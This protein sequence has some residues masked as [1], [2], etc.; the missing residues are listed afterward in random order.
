MA[1]EEK[2]NQLTT[3]DVQQAINNAGTP[4]TSMTNPNGYQA[5]TPFAGTEGEP[6]GSQWRN[7]Q[8]TG[9]AKT[10]YKALLKN[11][12]LAYQNPY[13]VQQQQT[14]NNLLGQQPFQYNVNTDALYQ[15]IKDNYIKQGRQS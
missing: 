10:D 2:K 7:V 11:Q 9:N 4:T 14:L 1:T 12:P 15:Q 6:R 8:M 13:Y 5:I 3:S